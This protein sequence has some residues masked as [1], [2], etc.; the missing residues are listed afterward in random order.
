MAASTLAL[1]RLRKDEKY[2]SKGLT[3]GSQDPGVEYDE[4]RA[5]YVVIIRDGYV[6]LVSTEQKYFLP[7]GGC[8]PHEQ[9]E[10]TVVRE[11]R[12]E[13]ARNVK[14]LN[15]LGGA[16][17][18]FFSSTDRRYYKMLA[19]FFAGELGDDVYSDK[20]EHE[21][22]WLPVAQIDKLCFHECHAWAVHQ[23]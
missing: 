1:G 22:S 2:I 3:F 7:G 18:Y 4:R 15:K 23:A 10:A 21:L 17:Q 8:L 11:V 13:L 6:A 19:T 5:A 20:G 16:T 14:L 12:E 9:P